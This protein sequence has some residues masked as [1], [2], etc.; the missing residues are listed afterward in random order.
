M[1][2]CSPALLD[3]EEDIFYREKDIPGISVYSS[4]FPKELN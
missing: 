1:P 4:V 3:R 2:I